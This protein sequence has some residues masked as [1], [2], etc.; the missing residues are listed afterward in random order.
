MRREPS[1]PL[2]LQSIASSWPPAARPDDPY[3]GEAGHVLRPM[4]KIWFR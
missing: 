2:R 3:M 1:R 4:L